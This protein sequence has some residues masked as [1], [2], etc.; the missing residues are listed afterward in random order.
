MP[1]VRR[2]Q[3]KSGPPPALAKKRFTYDDGTTDPAPADSAP[4]AEE[5]GKTTATG[6]KAATKK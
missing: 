1:R 3:F 4:E 2:Q 5:T 6:R